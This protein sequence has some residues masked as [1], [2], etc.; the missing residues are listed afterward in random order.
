[1]KAN[2][3]TGFRKRVTAII[4]SSMELAGWRCVPYARRSMKLFARE[5]DVT[6]LP[7]RRTR[8]TMG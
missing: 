4:E 5:A 1:M 2:E 7:F 8:K 6:P 3:R